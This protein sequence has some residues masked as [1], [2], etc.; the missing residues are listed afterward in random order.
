MQ[1]KSAVVRC[2]KKF[3]FDIIFSY[4]WFSYKKKKEGI[5]EGGQSFFYC[6]L[7]SIIEQL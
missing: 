4:I 2:Q 6:F 3:F 7:A 5:K 1:T